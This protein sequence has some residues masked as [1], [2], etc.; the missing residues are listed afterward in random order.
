[1]IIDRVE[2]EKY[3]ANAYLVADGPGGSGVLIDGNGVVEPLIERSSATA[4]PSPT[5][6]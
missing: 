1:M 5:S 4:S 6:S 3:L 2:D